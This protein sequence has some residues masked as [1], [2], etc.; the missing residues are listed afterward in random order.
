MHNVQ[1]IPLIQH[2]QQLPPRLLEITF[3][4]HQIKIMLEEEILLLLECKLDRL[5]EF[6]VVHL[7]MIPK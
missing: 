7:H 2:V 4:V 5:T 3:L 6:R 1:L